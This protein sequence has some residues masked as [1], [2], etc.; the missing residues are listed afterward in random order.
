[1]TKLPRALFLL[2][3]ALAPWFAAD[4]SVASLVAFDGN[5]PIAPTPNYVLTEQPSIWNAAVVASGGVVTAPGPDLTAAVNGFVVQANSESNLPVAGTPG[6]FYLD[7]AAGVG[8][9]VTARGAVYAFDV[10]PGVYTLDYAA[11]WS[12]S[13]SAAANVF[14]YDASTPLESLTT[15]HRVDFNTG[16]DNSFYGGYSGVNP[17]NVDSLIGFSLIHDSGVVGGPSSLAA[18][19]NQFAVGADD[20][21]IFR[22]AGQGWGDDSSGARLSLLRLNAV[23][24]PST[25]LL[26]IV[27]ILA[28][29]GR[30]VQRRS[31]SMI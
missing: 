3:A 7:F 25:M 20:L 11:S 19:T 31:S 13:A 24:E 23:P 22:I 26:A 28:A 2:T 18:T 29:A 9:N 4:P 14:L 8:N 16:A 12:S 6:S 21:I 17:S 5:G 27:G 1:M 10:A 30:R 15:D